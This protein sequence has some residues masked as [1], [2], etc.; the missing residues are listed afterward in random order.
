M[1]KLTAKEVKN[2]LI[3]HFL[4]GRDFL[5]AT[6]EMGVF[7]GYSV[8][9]DIVVLSK[10]YKFYEIEI[11]T[12]LADLKGELETID[13]IINNKPFNKNLAKHYKHTTYLKTPEKENVFI[14]HRFYFSAPYENKEEALEILKKT[15]YGLMDLHGNVYKVAKDLHKK[16]IPKNFV[17]NMLRRLSRVNYELTKNNEVATG[18]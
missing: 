17:E 7:D 18:Q 3:F 10:N 4:Y 11:K 2:N 13:Y 6:T 12:N 14:P 5:C 15:P 8:K 1:T 9:A 16:P